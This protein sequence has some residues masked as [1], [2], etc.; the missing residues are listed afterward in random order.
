MATSLAAQL[1]QIAANSKSTLNVKAQ[2]A[3]HSK[4]LIFEPRIAAGQNYQSVWSLCH[5]G[6]EELC[7]LDS[8]FLQFA[9]TLFSEQSQEEDRTQMTAAEN[10]E[11]DK[12]IESFLRLAGGRLRLMPTIKAVE[13]LI[14]R[15]RIHEYNTAILL[16]TFL[17]YHSIPVFVTLMS[18]LPSKLPHEYRFLDPYIRSLTSPPRA[19]IV[20]QATHHFEFLSIISAYTLESCRT[21]QHYQALI[22]F[23]GGI[24]AEA[25]NGMVDNL[26]S[27]RRS[28]QQDNDQTLLQQIAPILADSLVMKKV[29]PLQIASYMVIAVLA[30]KAKLDDVALTAFMDQLVFGWTNET[31]R[32]GIVCLSI[33]AQYRSAKQLPSKVTKALLKIQ[34]LQLLLLDMWKEHRVDRLANGLVLALIDRLT[35][36]G[37]TR[38]LPIIKTILA[39]EMLPEK[40]TIVIFKMLIVAAHK[41]DGEVDQEGKARKQLGLALVQLSQSAG[42]GGELFRKVIEDVDFDIEELELKLGA[43]IQPRKTLEEAPK[44]ATMENGVESTQQVEDLE[45]ALT[46]LTTK[47]S[48]L[49]TCLSATADAV[50]DEISQLFLS[51]ASEDSDLKTFDEAPLLHRVPAPSTCFYF[52]FYM[53]LWLGPYPT[54]A[55]V[56]ALELAKSRA[57]EQDCAKVDLQALLPYAIA[58]LSDPAKKVRRAAADLITVLGEQ[59]GNARSKKPI[60]GSK[61]LY[62]DTKGM[63][64][65]SAEASQVFLQTILLPALEESILHEDHMS[66]VLKNSLDSSKRLSVS[67]MES[68]KKNR[69]SHAV[70]LSILSFLAS[71]VIKTP[72]IVLKVRLLKALNQIRGVSSTTRTE[73]LLPALQWW[74]NLSVDEAKEVIT[75]ETADE[76]LLD[77]SSVDIVVANDKAGLDCFFEIVE[78]PVG[79]N[80]AQLVRAI[81]S[82]IRR[83]WP[84]MKDDAKLFTAQRMLDLSQR[85]TASPEQ[86]VA[87]VEAADLLRNVD[88]TTDILLYFLESLQDTARMATEPPANKRRRT[89]SSDHH[90]GI[91][92]QNSQELS[93]ALRKVTFV[94]QIVE[95]SKPAEH[96]QLLQGLFI[97]LSDLQLLRTLVGSEL[98]YLQN[99]VLSSLLAMMPAYR[100]N[101]DLK[102]DTSVGHGDVLVNCIQKSSSPAVQNSA[103]LLVASLAKTAP[104]VV[105]HSVMPIF[106]FMGSSVL[107]QGDDYSAH[108]INQTIK[109]VVPPLIDTFRKGRRNVVAS[110]SELLSSF[111]V[112]YEHIPSHRKHDLFISLTENLGPQDFLFALVAMFVDK[113]GTSDNILSFSSELM[114]SFSVETQLLSLVKFLDLLADMFKPKPSLSA[115]LFFGKNEAEDTVNKTALKELTLLPYILANRT[116]KKE[117]G[118]LAER[119]DME[120]AK[121]RELYAQLLEDLLTLADIVKSNPSLHSKCGDALSNLLNLLSI[122]EFIKAV[123]TLLDRP[124]I[125]LR[126]KVLRALEVRIENE[127]MADSRS[128]TALLAFLPQLTAVIRDSDDMHYKHTAVGCVDKISEKYGKKD[129]EAVAAAASTIAGDQC[130][131]QADQR[132]RVMALLCL[133]SLVDVLQDGIVPV[134]PAAIPKALNYLQ[135]SMAGLDSDVEIHN[136]CYSFMTALAQYLPYMISGSYLDQLL[137]SSNMSAEAGLD[138]ECNGNRRQCLRFLAKQLDAKVIFSALQQNWTKAVEAGYSAVK[139]FIEILGVAIDK[140]SKAAIAKNVTALSTIFLNAFD[141]RR[142]QHLKGEVST[143]T[144][145]AI[146][147]VETSINETALKMIYK[148]NDAAFRPIFAQIVEWSSS[149]QPKVDAAGLLLRQQSVYGFLYTFFDNL[150]SIVTSYTSY[151]VDNAA[152]IL[153]ETI[154]KDAES[155]ALWRTVLRTLTKSFE[156]DQ[157]DFWQAPSHFGAIGPLLVEQFS[158][159]G[160]LDLSEELIPAIVELGAAADS[161][162]HQKELNGAILKRLRS[163]NAA[164]R[165]AAVQCEQALTDKLG[166]EWL[167][168]L[169]EMLPYISELQEDDDEVVDRETHRWIVKIESVLGESLDSMLQ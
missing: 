7:Q 126:H 106:T 21:Q 111:V 9:T 147:E 79:V 146:S 51:I 75:R 55:R 127:S 153:K 62:D 14:R 35:K 95:A 78:G 158:H 80:R 139:E 19:T 82:R 6:F 96:P 107:R 56:R 48:A 149:T 43:S 114:G 5:E 133:A 136:A 3:A 155:K 54:L 145:A 4:S 61:N 74:S 20:H 144:L 81:F 28:I 116:L 143:P 76:S 131:G 94:L 99:L 129:L 118:E 165:L 13:W 53:R 41:I 18:I 83:M 140:H 10:A 115:T 85:S 42:Q 24:M 38:G 168:M 134:L 40:Q 72:L 160:L 12:R 138:D 63:N 26:R 66:A 59:Q 135:Q 166:E 88:L 124:K 23:W 102:I 132:L 141:L 70:R 112:A 47:E 164:V 57:K 1:A 120:A 167:A 90:R 92:N 98:G 27:G 103:L 84:S 31:V 128:R 100:D 86:E 169:P 104:D 101:R 125:N 117:I 29:P 34:D 33:L 161:Q 37:D 17:P 8:R 150:K 22:S 73:L 49:S 151:I 60:W 97:T 109:E 44:D 93:H 119:D 69:T 113:Y 89:S 110:A 65:L 152:K 122:G 45:S 77:L 87:S 11:L 130:L 137:A 30:S 71:H 154:P 15:F 58:A 52:T 156:H 142:Q 64:W 105:L 108:V 91:D 67:E 39:E 163:E 2:R 32:P 25:V 157:D 123:E 159:A 162:E 148:L 50:F 36:K 68:S 46:R 121:I 16:T